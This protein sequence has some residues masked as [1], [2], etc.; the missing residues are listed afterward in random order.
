MQSHVLCGEG[1]GDVAGGVG[2]GGDSGGEVVRMISNVE[3][4][5]ISPSVPRKT[6]GAAL[7]YSAA[8]GGD[9]AAVALLLER[10]AA[11]WLTLEAARAVLVTLVGWA[12]L[13]FRP[14]LPAVADSTKFTD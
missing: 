9:E 7:A 1:G 4:S 12:R 10:R 2:G 6:S 11:R 14:F 5:L 13:V 8:D 3:S